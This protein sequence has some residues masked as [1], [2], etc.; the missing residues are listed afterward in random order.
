MK[1]RIA[2]GKPARTLVKRAELFVATSAK[3]EKTKATAEEVI[4][5]VDVIVIATKKAKKLLVR[6]FISSKD[7][8][9][10]AQVQ[11]TP[12]DFTIELHGSPGSPG[13]VFVF[14]APDAA[15]ASEWA[16]LIKNLANNY[17]R[18]QFKRKYVCCIRLN[19][20]LVHFYNIR[21]PLVPE[22]ITAGES[23]C[24]LALCPPLSSPPT[25]HNVRYFL[26]QQLHL[27]ISIVDGLDLGFASFGSGSASNNPAM[28]G[29]KVQDV[30]RT[31]MARSPSG[32]SWKYYLVTSATNS[33][34]VASP[35]IHLSV[36]PPLEVSLL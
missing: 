15:E 4:A 18:Q 6:S 10:V 22:S 28:R 23:Q 7:I 16:K 12:N 34:R 9:D 26:R 35:C 19:P 31:Q 3:G 21:S 32:S 2:I 20:L 30:K 8:R 33:D 17:A 27:C 1:V 13:E 25:I 36:R 24:T 11:G 5:M 29:A 14:T